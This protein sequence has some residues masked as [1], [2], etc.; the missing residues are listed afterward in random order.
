MKRI[1]LTLCL[2]LTA[3][4]ASAQYVDDMYDTTPSKPKK[5]NNTTA[6]SYAQPAQTPQQQTNSAPTQNKELIT[7]YE[8]ALER[9]LNALRNTVDMDEA[10]WQLLQQY[11]GVLEAKYDKN[12]YNIVVVGNDMWVEPQ[13]V[14]ALFDGSDPAEGVIKYNEQIKQG[15]TQPAK[16]IA[17]SS[18]SSSISGGGG[19]SDQPIVININVDPWAYSSWNYGW[20][21]PYGYGWGYSYG[22]GGGWYDPWYSPWS[23]HSHYYNPWY[24]P[25]HNPWHSPYYYN[26]YNRNPRG[27]YYGNSASGSP[28]NQSGWGLGGTVR[29]PRG[30]GV[31]SPTRS[32]D[33]R[34]AD[35]KPTGSNTVTGIGNRSSRGELRGRGDAVTGGVAD[36]RNAG[37][38]FRGLTNSGTQFERPTRGSDGTRL[39]STNNYQ[40]SSRPTRSNSTFEPST[41][42]QPRYERPTERPTRT[43]TTRPVERPSTIERTSTFERSNSTYSRPS[44]GG[45]RGGIVARPSRGR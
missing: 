19:S 17:S 1:I 7:T 33:R 36:M 32:L 23:Y 37:N 30:S 8:E 5:K 28:R 10:Y 20:G 15:L 31:T 39:P 41:T 35:I 40:P 18:S 14:T 42:Y 25:W 9:R 45:S 38:T 27:T 34:L 6:Q 21:Y 11:Q 44:G 16:Q 12:L 13:S 26:S 4:A 24:N 29:E 22:W 43:E 3:V 2:A